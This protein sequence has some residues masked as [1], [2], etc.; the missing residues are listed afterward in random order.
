MSSL[1]PGP[2]HVAKL[3]GTLGAPLVIVPRLDHTE[4]VPG[5]GLDHLAHRDQGAI[6]WVILQYVIIISGPINVV[7]AT[8][9]MII[10]QSCVSCTYVDVNTKD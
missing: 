3:L 7:L 5:P 9:K 2:G 6:L 8:C 4:G 1:N 10:L